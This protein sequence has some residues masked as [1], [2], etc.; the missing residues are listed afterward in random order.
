MSTID[1]TVAHIFT[2]PRRSLPTCMVAVA[3][4]TRD[5]ATPNR[6]FLLGKT[7]KEPLE[8]SSRQRGRP[9]CR[10][11]VIGGRLAC[12]S[13]KQQRRPDERPGDHSHDQGG[14]R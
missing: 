9:R 5:N 6:W 14:E 8:G 4:F 2:A 1:I 7:K 10:R 13:P 12:Q 3:C 11:V